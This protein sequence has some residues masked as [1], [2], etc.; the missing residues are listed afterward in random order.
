MARN[1]WTFHRGH[2]RCG[3]FI[4]DISSWTFAHLLIL[5]CCSL[6]FRLTAIALAVSLFHLLFR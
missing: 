4:V 5:F 3:H 2:L 1:H 6:L